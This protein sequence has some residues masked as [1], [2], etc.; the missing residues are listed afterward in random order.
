M[1]GS[2]P[3]GRR[4]GHGDRNARNASQADRADSGSRVGTAGS[5]EREVVEALLALARDLRAVPMG[6]SDSFRGSL[7]KR[8]T[9]LPSPRP[10]GPE[11]PRP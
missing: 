2:R 11:P 8:L 3:R 4:A 7:R 1:G 10:G 6:P 9:S 5:P